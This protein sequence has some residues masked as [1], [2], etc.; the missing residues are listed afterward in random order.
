M[1]SLSWRSA[2]ARLS[3][4]YRLSIYCLGIHESRKKRL[5]SQKL[6][7]SPF[8]LRWSQLLLCWTLP[9]PRSSY[10]WRYKISWLEP[11]WTAKSYSSAKWV[12]VADGRDHFS[13]ISWVRCR[14][15]AKSLSNTDDSPWKL[16]FSWTRAREIGGGRSSSAAM[17]AQRGSLCRII[18]PRGRTCCN[19]T[20]KPSWK[21]PLSYCLW[22]MILSRICYRYRRF[23]KTTELGVARTRNLWGS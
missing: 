11:S 6:R 20:R 13:H 12:Q 21:P 18:T 3:L 10:Q 4:P 7:D 22:L 8:V 9:T 2:V 5:D 15:S 14:S 16:C 19:Y 1:G 23:P 17:Q